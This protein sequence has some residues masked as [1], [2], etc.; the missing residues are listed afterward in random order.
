MFITFP[1]V[2]TT[3]FHNVCVCVC[4][5]NFC[6]LEYTIKFIASDSSLVN[7]CQHSP[8]QIKYFWYNM[9]YQS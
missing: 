7:I 4:V 1:I 2:K 3:S 6:E 9:F 5:Y 8:H